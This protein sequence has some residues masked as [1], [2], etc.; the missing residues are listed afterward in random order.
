[1]KDTRR[2]GGVLTAKVTATSV[3]D[4]H[5]RWLASYIEDE[6]DTVTAHDSLLR[7]L[8]RFA[9]RH[10]ERYGSFD[11]VHIYNADETGIYFDTPPSKMLSERGNPA[12]ITAELKHSARLTA[13][14]TIRADGLKLPLLF[15]VR[16]EQ[17][18]TIE[19]DELPTYPKGHVYTVQTK[20]W[21]D[22]RVWEFYWM[23]ERPP[24]LPHGQMRPEVTAMQKRLETIA[25]TI[26]TW[27]SF[28][29]QTVTK[30]L[31]K[32]RLTNF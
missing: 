10:G 31:N 26:K 14:C 8:R 7:L 30:A 15:I 6:K 3:R 11:A 25:R 29:P 5:P 21:I 1:M 16:G 19:R 32:A 4:Q 24:P 22:S 23:D 17:G 2:E 9:Y 27:K 13:V 28:K 18:G 12:S 20:A